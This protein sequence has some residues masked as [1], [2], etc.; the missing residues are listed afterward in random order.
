MYTLMYTVMNTMNPPEEEGDLT[1]DFVNL[2]FHL[3]RNI[4]PESRF[5]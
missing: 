5:S 1:F 4:Q 3:L 2:L